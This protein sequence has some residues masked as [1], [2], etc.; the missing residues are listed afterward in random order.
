M[1]ARDEL[2]ITLGDRQ[3]MATVP[4]SAESLE[5][6]RFDPDRTERLGS[7][8]KEKP[9]GGTTHHQWQFVLTLLLRKKLHPKGF[10][11]IQEWTL[12]YGSDWLIPDVAVAAQ[13]YVV[14]DRDYLMAPAYLCVEIVSKRQNLSRLFRKCEQY[15]AWGTPF[16]WVIDPEEAAFFEYHAGLSIV[17]VK[18]ELTAGEVTL[19]INELLAGLDSA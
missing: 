19:A 4:K 9:V 18:Q 15:H 6:L 14:D 16:C 13:G 17:P 11:A 3:L 2:V 12:V 5:A 8:I 1:R 7:V 10:R